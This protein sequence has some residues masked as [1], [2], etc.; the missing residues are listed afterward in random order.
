MTA[1]AIPVCVSRALG[2]RINNDITENLIT[3]K[4]L[5]MTVLF[6]RVSTA[7]GVYSR[8]I[9]AVAQYSRCRAIL[10]VATESLGGN[11]GRRASVAET[12]FFVF[13]FAR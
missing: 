7:R 10:R 12:N 1:T 11:F 4:S 8:N 2:I 13:V 6:H 9:L 3:R 5:S